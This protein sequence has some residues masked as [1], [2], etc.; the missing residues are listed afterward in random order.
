MKSVIPII[1][2]GLLFYSCSSEEGKD[3]TTTETSASGK[4]S[5]R[6]HLNRQQIRNAEIESGTVSKRTMHLSLLVNGIID[7]HPGNEV[8]ISAP[9]G[10]Y[11]KK[12]DLIP[13]KKVSKGMVLAVLEDQQYI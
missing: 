11:L 6:I 8:S 9:L 7:V 2:S 3:Q 4:E 1:L 10:G 12:T 5:N 13:G